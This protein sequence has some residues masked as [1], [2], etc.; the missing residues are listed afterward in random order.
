MPSAIILLDRTFVTV[1]TDSLVMERLVKMTT[2]AN[3]DFIAAKQMQSASTWTRVTTANVWKAL[4]VMATRTEFIE[5]YRRIR[6]QIIN[7]VIERSVAMS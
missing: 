4:L 2:S 7:S 3:W 1:M 6:F 5:N